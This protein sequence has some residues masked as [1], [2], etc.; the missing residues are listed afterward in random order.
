MRKDE[1]GNECPATLGEYLDICL[2]VM[3]PDNADNAAV[4]F[5]NTK[6]AESA[7]GRDELVLAD[8]S[9]MRALLMPMLL[10]P[11]KAPEDKGKGEV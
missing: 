7:G 1:Q 2:R 10:M 8:D 5:L 9:Q 11:V 6:I 3:G 4:A